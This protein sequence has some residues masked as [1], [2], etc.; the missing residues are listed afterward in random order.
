[1]GIALLYYLIVYLKAKINVT[2]NKA[3]PVSNISK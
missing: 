2:D 1:M 3:Y